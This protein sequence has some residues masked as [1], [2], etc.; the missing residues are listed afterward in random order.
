MRNPAGYD[1]HPVSGDLYFQD[2][3][4]DGVPDPNEP[5]SADELNFIAEAD[6]GGAIEDFGFPDDYIEYRTGD[7]IGGGKIQPLVA[8]TPI[9]DPA[10]GAE[11]EGPSEIAFAPPGFPPGLNDGMFIGMHGKFNLGGVANE[12]NPLV[13]VDLTDNSYFHIISNTEA[14]VGHLDGLLATD[15]RLYVADIS[16]GGSLSGVDIGT[17]VIYQIRS[18]LT[19]LPLPR[20]LTVS[21]L[22]SMK[23]FFDWDDVPGATSYT[24]EFADNSAFTTSEFRFNL[25]ASE[26]DLGL[27]FLDGTYFWRVKASDGTNETAYSATA[28]FVIIPTFDRWAVVLLALSMMGYVVWRSRG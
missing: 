5:T 17:G 8:F 12:E 13:Y 10:T 3:G 21:N 20:L 27:N 26:I 15:D 18:I 24:F 28:S 6:L 25:P 19:D 14:G 7:I 1:W 22:A 9:P 4:I 16:P 11:G 2:N 23:P